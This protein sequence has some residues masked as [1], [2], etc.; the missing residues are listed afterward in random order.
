MTSVN[1][2]YALLG[3]LRGAEAKEIQKA[4]R[5]RAKGCHPDL[6]PGD[7]AAEEA[8]K[9]LSEAYTALNDPAQ[10]RQYD[11]RNPLAGQPRPRDARPAPWSNYGRDRKNWI[12][13]DMASILA[14]R[15]RRVR[16]NRIGRIAGVTCFAAIPLLFIFSPSV[17]GFG[18]ASIA[19]LLARFLFIGGI[20]FLTIRPQLKRDF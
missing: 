6:H 12:P 14:D 10:R 11:L 4:Y 5:S 17:G 18:T 8:F 7:V 13:V 19:G 1:D 9:A 16:S 3:V 15:E 2:Y 20:Y